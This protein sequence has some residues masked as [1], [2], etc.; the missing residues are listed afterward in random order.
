MQKNILPGLRIAFWVHFIVGGIV[1]LCY[2]LV[3]DV[4]AGAAGIQVQDTATW[5]LVGAAICAFAASSWWAVHE[6]E[7]ARVKIIV[8]AELVW[9]VLATLVEIS[10]N[11]GMGYPVLAWSGAIIM[12]LFAIA[13][14]YF[15][16]R[17]QSAAVTA[18]APR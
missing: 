10:G 16:F 5:R 14:G 2:L 7:W 3:P 12:A 4:L 13:F 15:Y 18:V 6:V 11:I 1:G 17:Q 9:T 8:E